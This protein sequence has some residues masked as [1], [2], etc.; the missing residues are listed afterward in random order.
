[1]TG[2]DRQATQ[3]GVHEMVLRDRHQAIAI[4][5]IKSCNIEIG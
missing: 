4:H 5:F 3:Q 2:G 1:M